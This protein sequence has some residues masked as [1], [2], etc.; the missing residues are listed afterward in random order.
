MPDFVA[1]YYGIDPRSIPEALPP[2]G[3]QAHVSAGAAAELGLEP[4]IPIA[5]RAG[6]QPNNAFSLNVMEPGEIAATGG[7]SGV[8]Y[9]VTDLP[10]ADSLSRVNT[11]L[12]VNHSGTDAS[13]W[14]AAVYQRYRYPQCLGETHRGS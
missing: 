7:T 11:F 1:D 9:G 8:V 4:G 14:R 2:I 5:Y 10:K 13:L 6:D 3:I 12:H